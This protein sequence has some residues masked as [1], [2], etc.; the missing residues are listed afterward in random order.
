[1]AED[2]VAR[3]RETAHHL[4]FGN[5]DLV[6]E[7]AD[8]IEQLCEELRLTTKAGN[9]ALDKLATVWEEKERLRGGWTRLAD[10][11]PPQ[12]GRVFELR[13][14]GT[15]SEH[16]RYIFAWLRSARE[17]RGTA[18]SREHDVAPPL[19]ATEEDLRAVIG[20]WRLL[21]GD[22]PPA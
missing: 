5:A 1:M 15:A 14:P 21:P 3:L 4:D 19:S 20:W 12:D 7:A 17:Y 10:E 9:D 22:E 6:R 16:R 11:L 2:I 13:R 8:E 18:F